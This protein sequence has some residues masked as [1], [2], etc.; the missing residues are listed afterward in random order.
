MELKLIDFDSVFDK[1]LAE[2]IKKNSSKHTEEEWADIIPDLYDKFGDS[3]INAIGT[4]PRKYYAAMTDEELLTLL[5]RHLKSDVPPPDFLC[6]EMEKRG[7]GNC[8]ISLLDEKDEELLTYAITINADNVNAFGK[9]VGIISDESL[10]SDVRDAAADMLKENAD[11]VKDSLIKMVEENVAKDYALDVLCRV[12]GRD[13]AVYKILLNEFLNNLD[14]IQKYAH[15]LSSYGDE[16][17][18]P[19]LEKEIEREDISYIDFLELKYAIEKLGGEYTKERD[20]SSDPYY[21]QIH[22]SGSAEE[23]AFNS[24][25]LAKKNNEQLS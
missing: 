12:R 20:F 1:K 4:T 14:N 5:K 23:D 24:F 2:Y 10:S 3:Y 15:M 11:P 19:Y 13:E 18:L 25:M 16:R 21:A 22:N 9:Y 17:Y 6:S 8:F 7:S